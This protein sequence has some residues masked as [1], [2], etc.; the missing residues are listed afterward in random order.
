MIRLILRWLV[1]TLTILMVP[2]LIGGIR[3][4]SFAAALAAAAV[5]SILNVIL[6][7]ILIILTLPFTI[8]TLGLFLLVINAIVFQIAGYFVAGVYI[9]SFSAAFLASLVVT[10][11]SWVLNRAQGESKTRVFV[12]RPASGPRQTRQIN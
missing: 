11:V 7:P 10:F 6:K 9:E 1:L 8:L 2:S 12:S 3:V 5:L 4:E